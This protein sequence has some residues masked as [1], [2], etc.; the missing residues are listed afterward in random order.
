MA[1]IQKGNLV[2]KDEQVLPTF[3]L[4]IKTQTFG[5]GAERIVR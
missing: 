2:H 1:N 4:A 5:E 3:S